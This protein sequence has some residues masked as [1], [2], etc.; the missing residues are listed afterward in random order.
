[1]TSQ[2]RST[3]CT[4]ASYWI[5]LVVESATDIELF[6]GK[7]EAVLV[8]VKALEFLLGQANCSFH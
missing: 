2:K 4:V 5:F 8:G 1:M 3:W 6:A 7:R